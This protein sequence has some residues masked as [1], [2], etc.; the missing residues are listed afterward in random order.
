MAPDGRTLYVASGDVNFALRPAM[1]GK[2]PFFERGV[3]TR[4]WPDDGSARFRE[5]FERARGNPILL[6]E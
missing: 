4:L 2:T 6:K 3:T 5:L 1:Q